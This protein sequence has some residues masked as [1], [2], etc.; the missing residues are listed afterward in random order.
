MMVDKEKNDV[1]ISFIV[2]YFEEEKLCFWTDYLYYI[3][4][5]IKFNCCELKA[6]ED[7]QRLAFHPVSK[8]CTNEFNIC[9]QCK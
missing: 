1:L 4:R 3:G 9:K 7:H 6:R 2:K 5:I 8:A